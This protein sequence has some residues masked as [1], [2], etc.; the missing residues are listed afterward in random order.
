MFHRDHRE[1]REKR[2][3]GGRRERERERERESTV[4]IVGGIGIKLDSRKRFARVTRN[5]N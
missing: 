4:K 1:R 2:R 5:A 3:K